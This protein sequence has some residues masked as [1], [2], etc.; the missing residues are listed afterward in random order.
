MQRYEYPSLRQGLLA[1]W[2]PS[3]GASGLSLI[4]RS[5]R[6]NHAALLNMGVAAWAPSGG[7]LAI[8]FDG[9]NDVAEARRI[10]I[11]LYATLA[12]WVKPISSACTIIAK[13]SKTLNQWDWVLYH[14]LGLAYFYSDNTGSLSY[15]APSGGYHL[16]ITKSSEQIV[17]FINGV[18]VN[19]IAFSSSLTARDFGVYLG[20][21]YRD[22]SLRGTVEMDDVRIYDRPLTPGE[23]RL[24]A[25]RRG[26]GLTPLPDRAAGLP[27]KMSVNVGGTWRSA[28]AYLN[29]GGSWKLTQP[30]TNV[31]G[32][33]K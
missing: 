9:L 26:I 33:W 30:S 20:Y 4:D 13:Q 12:A 17:M 1:A 21:E 3:L 27:R 15:A 28:D 2:C 31:G 24:L 23:I 16:A 29:V 32:T 18:S 10:D 7:N 5:G 19:S 6:N 11:T 25:S 8:R 22:Q 14:Y